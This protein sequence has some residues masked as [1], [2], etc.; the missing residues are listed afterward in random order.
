MRALFYAAVF[1]LA[2][3][4]VQMNAQEA[5][6]PSGP[7]PALTPGDFLDNVG[8][9]AKA[10][11]R[12]LYRE[13]PP[14]TP[15]DRLRVAFMLGAL[16]GDS[17]LAQKAGDSQQFKNTNQ[18]LINYCRVL[19]MGEKA[20]PGFLSA[21]KAAEREDWPAVRQL[22]SESQALIESLLND[23]RDEDLASLVELGMWMRLFEITTAIVTNDEEIVNKTL[24][25]GSVPLLNSLKARYD[26]LEEATRASDTISKLG[27]VLEVLQRH[28]ATTDGHPSSEL[29]S[30]T[31]EKLAYLMN[32][33]TQK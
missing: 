30:M 6:P 24:C 3:G 17:Y 22:V 23:Q 12:Q 18:D 20:T 15:S 25:I 8:K 29:V 1:A 27:T 33:L 10:R 7:S 16:I 9:Q 21:A 13:A 31:S 28:W 26:K 19:G 14:A 5:P 4:G 32:R 11:W 2:L